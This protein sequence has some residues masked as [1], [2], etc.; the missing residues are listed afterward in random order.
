MFFLVLM[1]GK[2]GQA[3]P[4]FFIVQTPAASPSSRFSLSSNGT[5]RHYRQGFQRLSGLH[6][7]LRFSIK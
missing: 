3:L 1:P 2:T 5:E 7:C 4:L 6:G